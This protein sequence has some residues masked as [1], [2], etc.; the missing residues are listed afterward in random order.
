MDGLLDLLG[1]RCFSRPFEV[2]NLAL[3]EFEDDEEDKG[4]VPPF[5]ENNFI[6]GFVLKRRVHR[7]GGNFFVK[8]VRL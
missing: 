3:G 6:F 7:Q 2:E 5:L 4:V 8:G 1:R